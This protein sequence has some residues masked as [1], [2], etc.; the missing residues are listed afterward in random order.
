MSKKSSIHVRVPN[1]ET[2]K[3]IKEVSKGLGLKKFSSVKQLIKE[4]QN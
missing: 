3:A 1:K 4:L 2:R